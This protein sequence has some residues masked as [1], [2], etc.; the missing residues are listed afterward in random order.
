MLGQ[1][2][3]VLMGTCRAL[4]DLMGAIKK[5][6]RTVWCNLSSTM[7]LGGRGIVLLILLD[8]IIVVLFKHSTEVTRMSTIIS[9]SKAFCCQLENNVLVL[10]SFTWK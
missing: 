9:S 1:I 7:D 8:C 2:V 6:I 5:Y 3:T 4:L 10:L